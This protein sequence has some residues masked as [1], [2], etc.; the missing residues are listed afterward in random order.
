MARDVLLPIDSLTPYVR[1][2]MAGGFEAR[3]VHL[4]A[5]ADV[6]LL[7]YLEGG[8]ALVDPAGACTHLPPVFLVGAVVHPRRYLVEAGSR[9]VAVTF[10][11][12]GL[13]AC[14]GIPAVNVTGR[15]QP[16]GNV[17]A[18]VRDLAAEPHAAPLRLQK[19][20]EQMLGTRPAPAPLP[21]FDAQAASEPASVL[22]RRLGISVRQFERRCLV[23]LG[24]PLRQYRR[25]ARYS[26]AM[27]ALMMQGAGAQRLAD[28]AQDAH[29]V[30]QAHFTR[31]F[32]TLAGLPPGRF[33]RQRALSQYALWQF[34]RD[35][36]E[37]YLS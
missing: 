19:M 8:A 24:M 14:F 34:T 18:L 32:G 23:G 15:I 37:S 22:A 29:Y 27:A 28:L 31:D 9:F 17:T 3:E 25:L 4:P 2:V 35:E 1:H 12:G 26:A 21:S 13:H 7:V 11:P 5:C 33:L 10:R 20:L 30:D 16:F 6:Q 36:L